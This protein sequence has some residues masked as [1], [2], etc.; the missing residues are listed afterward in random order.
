[1]PFKS[2]TTA[3]S[4]FLCLLIS[5]SRGTILVTSLFFILSALNTLNE[6]LIGFVWIL[7]SLTSCSS[8]LI[9]VHSESTSVLNLRFLPFFIFIF[10]H[11]FSSFSVLLCQL[12]I[13]YLFWDFIKEISHIVPTQDLL[14]NYVSYCSLCYSCSPI[15][16]KSF[17][18][19]STVFL[20]SPW[21]CALL[22]HTWNISLFLVLSFL[23]SISLLYVC[24]CCSWNTLAPH[25]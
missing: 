21:L 4:Y 2:V 18:S 15:F 22:C 16:F 12:G 7:L 14:Q 13:I 25:P 17:D 24:T 10:A 23:I 8:I 6:K 11:T 1:M 5:I 3:F 20:Y 19:S 9:Y